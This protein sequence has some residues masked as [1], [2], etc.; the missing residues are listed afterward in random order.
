MTARELADFLHITVQAVYSLTHEHKIP[1]YAPT[2][3]RILFK[4]S[5]MEEYVSK[6]RISSVNE[7]LTRAQNEIVHDMTDR[8]DA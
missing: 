6:A 8:K 7:L 1:Y 5:E 3:R 4:R 2:G